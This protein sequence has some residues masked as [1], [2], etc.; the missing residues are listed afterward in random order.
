L[1]CLGL[2]ETNSD[3]LCGPFCLESGCSRL[4][5]IAGVNFAIHGGDF[6]CWRPFRIERFPWRTPMVLLGLQILGELSSQCSCRPYA[7]RGILVLI[8][9]L[10]WEIRLLETV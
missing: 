6:G 10:G 2:L 3:V 1:V 5:W 8:R 9:K 4:R 7:G